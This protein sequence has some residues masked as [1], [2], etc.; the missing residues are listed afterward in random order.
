MATIRDIA[1]LARVSS[2]T[3]SRVINHSGYVSEV[4]REKVLAAIEELNYTPNIHAQNLRRGR[5]RTLGI[6]T[7]TLDDTTLARIS[8]FIEFAHD[9]GYTT[10][11]FFTGDDSVRELEALDRLKAKEIDG[12]FII[13][14]ANPWKN[15]TPYLKYGPLV[16]VH[17]L[18]THQKEINI[19][20]V[21]SDH[22][23]GY[24]KILK[25][26]W[27][28]GYKKTYHFLAYDWGINTDRRVQ[29]TQDFYK[30]KDY[31]VA[32]DQFFYNM[33]DNDVIIE[34]LK[35]INFS[36]K[37]A[38]LCFSDEVAAVVLNYLKSKQLKVPEEIAVVG[39]DNLTISELMGITSMDYRI[40]EQGRNAARLLINQLEGQHKYD[41]V[42]LDFHLVKRDTT[43]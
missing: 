38:V 33:I 21:F 32:S 17:N 42:P 4:T 24:L 30:E 13:Y 15:I 11:L 19:P 7:S 39:F 40:E 9:A 1:K 22:Y 14:R 31:P 37:E 41:T 16:T 10:A 43:L 2:A 18:G 35:T 3:V 23:S 36:K 8:P 6:I 28:H 29:A 26:L 12:A 25:D 34:S 27:A 20:T 5:T